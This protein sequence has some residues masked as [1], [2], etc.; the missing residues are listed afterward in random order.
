[1][2]SV[3]AVVQASGNFRGLM[4]ALRREVGEREAGENEAA[5]LPWTDVA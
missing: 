1:M 5:G 4:C 2:V 3:A